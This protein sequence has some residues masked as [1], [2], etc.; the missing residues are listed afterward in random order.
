MPMLRG[1]V[2]PGNALC[3]RTPTDYWAR[4]RLVLEILERVRSRWGVVTLRHRGTTIA[5]TFDDIDHRFRERKTGV[6]K[7]KKSVKRRRVVAR[8]IR[9]RD[10]GTSFACACLTTT[11]TGR[12]G[13]REV[14]HNIFRW[15]VRG[16]FVAN[17]EFRI[18]RPSLFL[19]SPPS[20]LRL[21]G[22][23][24]WPAIPG[25]PRSATGTRAPVES[26]VA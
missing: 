9:I 22:V 3:T 21:V 25:P 4:A 16:P 14:E 7:K 11:P 19:L 20:S 5:M 26:G 2:G 8:V 6:E 18:P 17:V 15:P 24:R 12:E 13:P 10:P 1:P 23:L